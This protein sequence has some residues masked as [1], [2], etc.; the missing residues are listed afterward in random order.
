MI[1]DVHT[2]IVPEHFPPRENQSSGEAWP[3]MD[4]GR[5]KPGAA[6]VMISGAN[7]RTVDDQCWSADRRIGDIA[8]QGIDRQVLSPM[9]R[10]LDYELA[11]VD[12]RALARHLNETIVALVRGNPDRFYGLGSVPLQD[13]GMAIAELAR[14][15]EVGLL[16]V[17]I[18]THVN[19]VSPGDPRFLPFWREAERLGLCV[20]VHAQNPTFAERLVGPAY[21]QN[22]IGFPMENAL[23]AM[24]IVTGGVMEECP[25]LRVCFSHGAGAFTQILPRL[26]HLWG[27]NASLREAMKRA[28]TEYARMLYYDDIFFDDRTLRY[29]M[30]MV[31]ASQVV[32]G[33][34]YPFMARVQ[35]P[36][37]EFDALGLSDDDREAVGWRNCLRFLGLTSA[38]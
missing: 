37:E 31:G 32:V 15:K 38:G 11:P 34:D 28:P 4:H 3:Y 18:T 6:D 36:D 7:Y 21:L 13:V 2:H 23:A 19:G 20:F 10:L 25:E 33:S 26:Q 29:L 17:E 27:A 8:A 9:P 5:S 30:E 35:R 22:A 12:G 1:I 16:G 24:S 14:V